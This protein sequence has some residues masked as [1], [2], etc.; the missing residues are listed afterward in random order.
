MG[1]RKVKFVDD[2]TH[3]PF[4][5]PEKMIP[6]HHFTKEHLTDLFPNYATLDMHAGSEHYNGIC[7]I[8]QKKGIPEKCERF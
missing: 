5:G 7:F 3:V 2:M 1:L 8:G 6:H 4:E